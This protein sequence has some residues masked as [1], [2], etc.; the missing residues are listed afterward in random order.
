MACASWLGGIEFLVWRTMRDRQLLPEIK[1]PL[2]LSALPEAQ[3]DDLEFLA[4]SAGEWPAW[5][6]GGVRLMTL[7]DWEARFDAWQEEQDV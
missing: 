7:P 1:D 5:V 2:R 3:L 6:D 4:V